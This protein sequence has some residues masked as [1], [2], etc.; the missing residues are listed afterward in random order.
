M[1]PQRPMRPRIWTEWTQWTIWML[2]RML[3]RAQRDAAVARRSYDDLRYELPFWPQALAQRLGA[4]ADARRDRQASARLQELVDRLARAS[5]RTRASTARAYAA[6][7]GGDGGAGAGLEN[8]VARL[9]GAPSRPGAS[10]A[11]AY[12]AAPGGSLAARLAWQP[13]RRERPP[14]RFGPPQSFQEH[15]RAR[16]LARRAGHR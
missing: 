7:P 11:R 9:G 13:G 3:P 4:R 2:P 5:S 1:R 8:L 15:P 14:L 6:A 10:T 12:A 16:C